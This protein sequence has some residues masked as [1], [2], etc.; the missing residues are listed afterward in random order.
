MPAP[1]ALHARLDALYDE[2]GGD[3]AV[4]ARLSHYVENV[5]PSVL[6]NAKASLAAI[7]RRRQELAEGSE[8]FMV[9]F[10]E[11]NR[12]FYLGHPEVFVRYDGVHFTACSEDDIQ[13]QILSAITQGGRLRPWKH[14]ITK[15]LLRAIRSRSPLDSIPESQTIQFVLGLLRPT[16][17]PTRDGAKYFLTVIGDAIR[18]EGDRQ[19]VY[20]TP[21]PLKDLVRATGVEVFAHLGHSSALQALKF[22]HH[23]HAYPT[24]RL[25][26][27]RQGQG[28]SEVQRT[29][30]KHSLD[31]LCVAHHYSSRFNCADGFIANG[32]HEAT[33]ADHA[34]HLAN[35]T[36][37]SLVAA[38]VDAYVQ[39]CAQ[40]RIQMKNMIFIWKKYLSEKRLP[41]VIFL[42]VLKDLLKERLAYDEE[43]DAFEG[44]TSPYVPMVAAFLRFWESVI[45]E[46]VQAQDEDLEVDELQ[47]LFRHWAR[48]E[49]ATLGG[50][51]PCLLEL[52]RHFYPEIVIERGRT[53]SNVRCT[54][55]DKQ[56]AV[57]DALD[58][59]LLGC[60]PGETPTLS[61]AYA[62]YVARPSVIRS[63]ASKEFFEK[64]ARDTL[65]AAVDKHGV[66]SHNMVV[67]A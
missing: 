10:L 35:H 17:F 43:S 3:D 5:L 31:Y 23:D 15:A 51:D 32:C 13:H 46:D 55:W 12:Y 42:G 1:P 22:K 38:F 37:P 56:A 30:M 6:R 28:T 40:R 66:L 47:T 62:H 14:K 9:G 65:G 34:M 36:P 26:P 25:L 48:T 29:L 18:G 50:A 20:L 39:S 19:L 44:V 61:A 53:L 58:V 67:D 24:C 11:Q 63:R 21:P 52:I 59:Y 4:C 7:A 27:G 64:I 54:L 41:S 49:G 33:L 2:Y 8:A 45:V 16:F 60:A 57:R